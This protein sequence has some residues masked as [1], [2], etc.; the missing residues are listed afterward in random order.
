MKTRISLAALALAALFSSTAAHAGVFG[1]SLAKCLVRSTTESDRT[2][3][4]QWLFVAMASHPDVHSL[5][6][7]PPAKAA[8]LNEKAAN[9][10]VN[11]ITQRCKSDTEEALKNEGPAALT[12]GFSVLGQVAMQGMVTN[13]TVVEYLSGLQK[14]VDPKVIEQ[15]LGPKKDK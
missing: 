1:D 7:V 15:A 14:H 12:Q 3:L 6:N 13:P 10:F 9:L 8:E 11:L 5:S 4:I 2:V